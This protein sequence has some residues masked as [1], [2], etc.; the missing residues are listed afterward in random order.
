[1][2]VALE[3]VERVAAELLSTFLDPARSADHTALIAAL[4]PHPADYRHV[5]APQVADAARSAYDELW[6][7]PPRFD[8]AAGSRAV[9]TAAFA[10]DLA[11]TSPRSNEFPGGYRDIARF[12]LADRAWVAWRFLAPGEHTGTSFDGL[13]MLDDRF[14]WFPKPWRVIIPPGLLSHYGE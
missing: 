9:V 13:V 5:L 4:R 14:A 2:A 6:K 8:V 11:T 7:S 3:E 10:Q 1:M 12:L